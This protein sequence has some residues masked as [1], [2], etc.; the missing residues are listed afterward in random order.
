MKPIIYKGYEIISE[1]KE[2]PDWYSVKLHFDDITT[3][4]NMRH[5]GS[6][7]KCK[8]MV[9]ESIVYIQKCVKAIHAEH[10]AIVEC[11]RLCEDNGRKAIHSAINAG[12]YLISVKNCLPYGQ[13]LK[14]LKDNCKGISEDTCEKYRSLAD[15]AHRRNFDDCETLRQ[16]YIKAGI[17][18]PKLKPTSNETSPNT[19]NENEGSEKEDNADKFVK[20]SKIANHL[21]GILTECNLEESARVLKILTPVIEWYNAHT[22]L[23]KKRESALN[24]GFDQ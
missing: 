23:T 8:Q 12:K 9:D 19:S 16:A 24:D 10:Q 5:A 14:W 2:N 7:D 6:L 11:S 13:W 20:A 3:K 22:E 4:A 17:I 21:V 1:G 15:S 18:K